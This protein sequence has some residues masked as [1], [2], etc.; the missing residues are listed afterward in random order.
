M[1]SMTGYGKGVSKR[2]G[3]T[4]T[5]EIKTVNHRFL[6]CNIKL[7]R[8]FLFVE[9]RVKKAVSSAISRGHVDLYLTYEQSSTDEGAYTVDLELANNYLTAVRQLENGTGLAN[10]VTL[11]TLLRVGDIVTRQQSVEDEDLLA[12]MTL[13]A[14]SEA[15]VNLK[16]MREKEGQSQK[17]DIASK[18]GTIEACLDRIKEFAPKVVEDYRALLNARIAEV[19]EPS[20]VDKQRLATE[21]ALY[22]DHCAI[23]EEITRLSTHISNMRSLLEATEPVGRKMDF[24][25]QEF[26]RETNTIGSKANDMRITKE[27]LAIKN[28]IEKMREQAANIE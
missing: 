7:P 24:L 11:S 25:V 12:E 10:D 16:V 4:I 8:N 20:L 14:A 15:L 18:L 22:A 9:D 3:K 2:D 28:E 23:D 6:D 19:V 27:V 5:I 17:A 21:V 26:N 13:E 1:H